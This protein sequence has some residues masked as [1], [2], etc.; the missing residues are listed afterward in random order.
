MQEQ[1]SAEFIAK[2]LDKVTRTTRGWKACCP[3]HDDNEP[4]LDLEDGKNGQPL[5]VCRAGCPQPKLIAALRDKGL[6]LTPSS[7]KKPGARSMTKEKF[8]TRP[9]S[10]EKASHKTT[11]RTMVGFYD[12]TDAD[13]RFCIR[14]SAVSRRLFSSADRTAKADGFRA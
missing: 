12:Y 4:S 8:G 11:S 3:A 9:S 6:W 1:Y 5:I 2:R 10:E 7:S 13:G 14:W